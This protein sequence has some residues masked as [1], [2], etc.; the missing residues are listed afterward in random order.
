MRKYFLG[1]IL[2]LS[3]A[4]IAQRTLIHCGQLI[5]VKNSTQLP[6]MTIVVEGNK[7]VEVQKG[8]TAASA[9]NTV[10][11][12]KKLTVM[13]GLIDMHVHLESET[14]PGSYLNGF[15]FNPADYAFQ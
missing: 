13:P 1:A 4:I 11:D 5:D 3:N 7:I 14:G 10:I 8:Y 2:L 12:L 15:T 9:G 6:A